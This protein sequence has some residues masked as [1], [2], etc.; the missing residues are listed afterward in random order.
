MVQFGRPN[1]TPDVTFVLLDWLN[2]G[3]LWF[4]LDGNFETHWTYVAEKVQIRKWP[5]DAKSIAA[6][7]TNLQR[8][9]AEP[10]TGELVSAEEL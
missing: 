6:L 5:G 9:A 2:T 8:L 10:V 7:I 1:V 4:P 3:S